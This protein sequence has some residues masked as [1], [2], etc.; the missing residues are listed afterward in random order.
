MSKATICL[1]M[2]VKNEAHVIE[3][4]LASAKPLIDRWCIVDTGSTD[5]TQHIIRRFM[6]GVPG[7]LHERPWKN[8][9]H[10]R[11]EALDLARAESCDYVLFIDAD[12]TFIAPPNFVWPTLTA[13]GYD[14]TAHYDAMRYARCAMVM[15]R[16]PWKWHGVIHEYLDCAIPH[17]V[18]SLAAPTI[19]V[20]HDGARARDPSTYLKDIAIL[21][22]AVRDEPDNA[23]NV[24]YL[25]QS[26]RDAGKLSDARGAYERRAAMGGWDEEVWYSRFQIAV[27]TERLGEAVERVSAAYLR[28]F[29][30][31][32][33]RAE[34]LVELA[35]FHRLR[36]EYAQAYLYAK[37]ASEMSRPNDRL[38]VDEAT[39]AW[40][41]LDEV[42][43]S[44]YY[45]GT[46][47]ARALGKS[48]VNTLLQS[49]STLPQ[50]ES[51]RVIKNAGFYS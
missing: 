24:F 35:R 48:A 23:R 42:A 10:N 14:L 22:S 8:F 26:Y 38:F 11:N 43:I 25:A 18:E 27:L 33:S 29:Q 13:S 12:E 21:E 30:S 41:A 20:Q 4:C 17:K 19:F 5:G 32:P 37:H 36:A 49:K 45:V 16:L 6:N 31:R 15:S 7:S 39:Y 50:T 47:E 2:I 9:A 40:R 44:A 51:E 3:R 28:A 34:P 1:N 46:Q